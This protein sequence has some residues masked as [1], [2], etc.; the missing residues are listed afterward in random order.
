MKF[1]LIVLF[2]NLTACAETNKYNKYYCY[3]NSD[4]MLWHDKIILIE[5]EQPKRSIRTAYEKKSRKLYKAYDEENKII[6]VYH[7]L[8]FKNYKIIQLNLSSQPVSYSYGYGYHQNR[9]SFEK[10]Y[11][12]PFTTENISR[13][14]KNPELIKYLPEKPEDKDISHAFFKG[15][16]NCKAL[17]S[18]EYPLYSIKLFLI[19]AGSAG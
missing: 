6:S 14:N 15:T 5:G 2:F 13:F 16:L 18:I 4:K 17:N 19:K 7:D 3:S 8:P 11:L 1:I 12:I 10:G 9:E